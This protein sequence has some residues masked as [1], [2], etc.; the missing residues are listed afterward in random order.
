MKRLILTFIFILL[1]AT[2]HAT[3]Y[4]V[5]NDGGTSA[6]CT[7]TT[8]AAYPGSGS[9][10]ACAFRSPATALVYGS[11]I[12]SGGDT[13]IIDNVDRVVGSGQAQYSV[14]YGGED[15]GGSS[16]GACTVNSQVNCRMANIPSGTVGSPTKIYGKNYASCDDITDVTQKAELYGGGR[17]FYTIG[18]GNN[19]E[20]KCLAV[21]DH[22]QCGENAPYGG[23]E[24]WQCSNDG[25][26][27]NFTGA[28]FGI[29]A[30][31]SDNILIEN[32]DV[33]G[34]SVD[35]VNFGSSSNLIFRRSNFIGASSAGLNADNP[36]SPNDTLTGNFLID[37]SKVLYS[38]C[39][40]KYPLVSNDI[41]STSNL[42]KCNSQSQCAGYGDAIAFGEGSGGGNW[43]IT[44]SDIS[45]NVQDGFDFLHAPT[46][47][48]TVKRSRFEGNAGNPIK[49][50][51][52]IN[53]V[54]NSKIIG[55]CGWF[56]GKSFTSTVDCVGG[57]AGFD[58]CRAG[59]N[60]LEINTGSASSTEILN[61]TIYSN[62]DLMINNS[63]Q[64]SIGTLFEIENNI[65][66]HGQEWNNGGAQDAGFYNCCSAVTGTCNCGGSQ[67]TS[68][69]N[70]V[71]NRYGTG[72]APSGTG[73]VTSDPLLNE[74]TEIEN[75]FY[76]GSEMDVTLASASSSA[77]NIA[78]ETASLLEDVDFNNWA[79]GAN[80]DAGA[81][82]EDTDGGGSSC[83]DEC[84][85]CAD[86]TECGASTKPCYWWADDT[87][88]VTDEPACADDCT[89]CTTQGTCE[90]SSAS[91]ACSGN[92]CWW[93]TNV[94]EPTVEPETCVS[95]DCSLCLNQPDCEASSVPCDW[96]TET[97]KEDFTTY[98]EV[99][100]GEDIAVDTFSI[101]VDTMQSGVTSY[102][103]KDYT[104]GHF[105]DFIHNVD[106]TITARTNGQSVGV[107]STNNGAQTI[108]VM[109][110][111][112][113]PG[114]V[115]SYGSTSTDYCADANAQGCWLFSE[116]SGT[117]IADSTSNSNTGNFKGAGEPAWDATDI[118][119]NVAGSAPN[120]TDFD[121]TDDYI[122][123][124]S[125]AS[126]D[127]NTSFTV[128][129]WFYFDTL[130]AA[131]KALTSKITWAAGG[132]GGWSFHAE[133]DGGGPRLH[134]W[135]IPVGGGSNE[136]H[137]TDDNSISVTTWHHI[138]LVY[139]MSN[140][141]NVPTIYIDGSAV[142]TTEAS[143]GTVTCADAPA[144]SLSIGRRGYS[145]NLDNQKFD[146][147][148][149]EVGY[150]DRLL[151][152][153]EVK[154]IYN[155]GLDGTAVSQFGWRLEFMGDTYAIDQYL[156]ATGMPFTRYLQME[157][158]TDTVTAKIY[159]DSDRTSLLDT[160][161]VT[162]DASLLQ[163][164]YGVINQGVT[165]TD[166]A[167]LTVDN[168][169]LKGPNSCVAESAATCSTDCTVCVS[170]QGC[171]GSTADTNCGGFCCWHSDNTC[172]VAVE[173]PSSSDDSH[174]FSGGSFL[175]SFP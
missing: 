53:H 128:V 99:D 111:T 40:M 45:F 32:V 15:I 49:L 144:S 118:N 110:Q 133:N 124:G 41:T 79:R 27:G 23:A 109:E 36:F 38:G 167:S 69:Y 166:T 28:R 52:G 105:G 16:N 90:A 4:Y 86:E 138:A 82:E 39:V 30:S 74:A 114:Y 48:L 123:A 14:G 42:Y 130:D 137:V 91:S 3:T 159:D 8:D 47:N 121:G 54:E 139:D 73:N 11:T 63:N 58:N 115:V 156:E 57:Y 153:K 43:T 21:T 107:W 149:T 155:Y 97:S 87:C 148:I 101:T 66:F 31:G 83:N 12:L 172:N 76:T 55:N 98:T 134:T 94:C 143:V 13:I 174:E 44:D 151:T 68:N 18:V 157:R 127:G 70:V 158:A 135:C 72:W 146:G 93:S 85:V 78:D 88:R 33:F 150:F 170:Q 29:Y 46:A 163:Y 100:A 7:G 17:Q 80:W 131:G 140:L 120:S 113:Q 96:S 160:L 51:N 67:P 59:G 5:R 35:N 125:D 169:D 1:C 141:S 142:N 77:Y 75:G 126:L 103:R 162:G 26:A 24:A 92:C 64:S 165:G 106:S 20:I 117:T 81:Y 136:E 2:A 6:Q 116:G 161:T 129:G 173:T 84:S 61:N 62:G 147:K 145:G 10:Q 154:D 95:D 171:E 22:D 56:E 65:L 119:F 122:D 71:Y 19:I 164:V 50:P 112:A 104:E 37:K 102:V 25:G 175:G 60:T 34:Q 108:D 9:G 152:A 132:Y 89:L 168:L